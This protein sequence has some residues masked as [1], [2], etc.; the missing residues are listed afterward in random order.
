MRNRDIGGGGGKTP[1]YTKLYTLLQTC[2]ML[3]FCSPKAQ[4]SCQ[5]ATGN[6]NFNKC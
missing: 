2:Q 4:L 3:G 6:F 5:N 1:N